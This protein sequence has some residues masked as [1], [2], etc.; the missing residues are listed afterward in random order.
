MAKMAEN[1]R[2]RLKWPKTSESAKM[3][4]LGRKCMKSGFL[5]I[6]IYKEVHGNFERFGS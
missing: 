3:T 1:G 5:S 4:L 2:N 6:K